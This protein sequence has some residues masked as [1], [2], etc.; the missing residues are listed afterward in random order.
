[1]RRR[2]FIKFMG[3]AVVAWPVTARAQPTMPVIGFMNLS[4]A[5]PILS[6]CIKLSAAR[7]RVIKKYVR[8]K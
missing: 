3:G 1:M 4:T 6:P 8:G 2:K 5:R 7:I